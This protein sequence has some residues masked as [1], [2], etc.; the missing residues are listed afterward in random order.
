MTFFPVLLLRG[1]KA[2]TLSSPPRI[3]SIRSAG[4]RLRRIL[5]DVVAFR[6]LH[7]ILI[8]VVINYR[9]LAAEIIPSRRRRNT[10]LDGRP[11]P[12]F[13]PGGPAFKPPTNPVQDTK[14]LH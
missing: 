8:G 6:T 7:I 2:K 12:W 14:Y 5:H 11:F 10:P 13:L 4:G 3:L 9:M 1:R